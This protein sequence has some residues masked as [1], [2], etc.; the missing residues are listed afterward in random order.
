MVANLLHETRAKVTLV[1]SQDTQPREII[2]SLESGKDIEE[3]I[4]K[5]LIQIHRDYITEADL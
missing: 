4:V 3:L 2:S 1:L 5:E